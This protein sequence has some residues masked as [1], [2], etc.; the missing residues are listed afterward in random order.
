MF[1]RLILVLSVL[2]LLS[3]SSPFNLTDRSGNTFVIES[4][5]L[6]HGGN[7]EYKTGDATRELPI[8]D[9][10]SLSVPEAEPKIFDG[11][12]FYPATLSLEDTI[13]VPKQGFICVE[14]TIIADNAGR[15][16]SIPLAN[17][18]ELNRQKKE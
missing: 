9:I 18:K 7:L 16:F 2:L 8:K 15:D 6:E 5:K 10:V 13:S 14:G 17:I 11:K 4:P 1:H 12:V 3:C